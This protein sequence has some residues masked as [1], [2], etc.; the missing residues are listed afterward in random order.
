MGIE[1]NEHADRTA[2]DAAEERKE[3]AEA[4]YLNEASLSHLTRATTENRSNATADWIRT[5]SGQHRQYCPP[6]G[7]MMRKELGKTRKELAS[8]F[9]QLL[10]GHAA[11]AEHLRR[12]NQANSDKCF[13]CG[14]GAIQTRHHLFIVCRRWGPEIREL[15]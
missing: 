9:F 2:R 14:S 15:W 7:G 8:H 6:K 5:R 13:W 1:G 11:T 10:S 12:V 3:R 4:A